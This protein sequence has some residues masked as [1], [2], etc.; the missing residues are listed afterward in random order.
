MFNY[1]HRVVNSSVDI[2]TKYDPAEQQATQCND[3]ENPYVLLEQA[4]ILN[5][6][7]NSGC[8]LKCWNYLL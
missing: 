8:V 1:S 6:L 2:L 5:E 7:A 3:N 4:R